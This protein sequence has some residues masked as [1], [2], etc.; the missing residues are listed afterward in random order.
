LAASDG[1]RFRDGERLIAFG[2]DVLRDAPELITAQGLDGYALL[3][4]ERALSSAPP[5]LSEGAAEVLH[6]PAGPVPECAAVVRDGVAGRPLVALGGG[7]VVDA[8]K[9]IAAADKLKAG[10]IPT[11]LAGSSFTPFHR[12]PAG[13][14][15]YGLVRPVLAVC[16]PALMASAPLPDLAAT[17][18]NA[19]AH[20]T[21]ALY[22]PGANPVSDGAALR[23]AALFARAL[24]ADPP[25]A[26]DLALAGLLAGWAV[27]TAGLALH[28]ALCQTLVRVLG[29]PHAQ[30]NA[31]M[32]PR[33]V[34]FMSRR[35]P[36]PIARLAAALGA[37]DGD[38][39]AAADRVAALAALAGATTLGELGVSEGDLDAVVEAAL[40]H[41]GV[42]ATPGGAS[43]RDL[44]GLLVA[45][46]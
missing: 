42:Q 38:P 14:E 11:T 35:A 45:A 9:A 26:H 20:A 30:T 15:G 4:T 21:E 44:R 39:S 41:R 33:S 5:E 40:E 37:E 24:P 3:T 1:F 29:T 22:A 23:A 12:M 18:M 32:L 7:R 10:A 13:V 25:D 2:D 6:V 28:H 16:D 8:A 27:G 17:A 43:E 34:A 19:L 36:E 46:L 31:V